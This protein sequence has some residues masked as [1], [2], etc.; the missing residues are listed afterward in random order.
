MQGVQWLVKGE[1]G[2]TSTSHIILEQG[3]SRGLEVVTF[4]FQDNSKSFLQVGFAVYSFLG[5]SR[6]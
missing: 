5:F 3:L 1:A 2:Q 4:M 6:I